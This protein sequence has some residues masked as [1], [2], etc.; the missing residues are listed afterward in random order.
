MR[1]I[2][3]GKANFSFLLKN[4]ISMPFL[5]AL[6]IVPISIGSLSW[7]PQAFPKKFSESEVETL[8]IIEVTGE[9]VK[10]TAR[11]YSFPL[12]VVDAAFSEHPSHLLPLPE[13]QINHPHSR[14]SQVL[15]DQTGKTRGIV[16]P[17]KPLKTEHPPYPRRARESGWEGRVVV[18]LDITPQGNVLTATIHESS[19]YSG[20]DNSAIQ[21]AKNWTF[22]P[23]KNGGFP[24]AST[25][26]IPVQFDLVQ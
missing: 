6:L 4:G 16:T 15:I 3:T 14:T 26:N 17:V 1:E 20:L 8:D 25:V 2:H 23:A 5:Y 7:V 12:P 13:I 10:T 18:Q 9:S 24:I 22:K 21:A 19:G 11:E